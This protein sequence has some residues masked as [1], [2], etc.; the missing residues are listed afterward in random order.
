MSTSIE[1]VSMKKPFTIGFAAWTFIVLTG[2]LIP[3]NS[4]PKLNWDSFFQLDKLVHLCFYFVMCILMYLSM[5]REDF[6]SL[7]RPQ[8]LIFSVLFAVGIGILIEILQ[9]NL[10]TGRYFDI[11]DILANMIGAAIAAAVIHFKL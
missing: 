8:A 7:W 4:I 10:N 9:S 5:V 11:F 1:Q 2:S 3:G 6:M